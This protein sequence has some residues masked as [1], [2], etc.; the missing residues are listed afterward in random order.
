MSEHEMEDMKPIETAYKLPASS[1]VGG[2]LNMVWL[3]GFMRAP[4]VDSLGSV[5]FW[6]Q[7]SN[8]AKS[9]LPVELPKDR[10]LTRGFRDRGPVKIRGHIYGKRTGTGARTAFIKVTEVERPT[11]LEMPGE[12]AWAGMLGDTQDNT[13][14]KPFF[15]NMRMSGAANASRVAGIV[16]GAMV[17]HG[18]GEKPYLHVLLQQLEDEAAAIPVRVYQQVD[19][20]AKRV[21]NGQPALVNGQIVV[22]NTGGVYIKAQHLRPATKDDIPHPAQWMLERLQRLVQLRQGNGGEPARPVESKP[23]PVSAVPTEQDVATSLDEL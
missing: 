4:V 12:L 3:A 23:Q 6:I 14:F 9:A 18:N 1:L 17:V 13:E 10:R 7:Q 5:R 19:V 11:S 2:A 15:G 21:K 22:D 8:N 20:Y 16:S